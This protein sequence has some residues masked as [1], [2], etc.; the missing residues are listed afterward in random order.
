MRL[1]RLALVV[2]VGCASVQAQEP[3]PAGVSEAERAKEAAQLAAKAAEQYKLSREGRNSAP[4]IFQEKSLLQWSN[5]VVGSIHGSVF[6]W[7]ENGRPKVVASIYK[8]YGPKNFHLGVEFH[9]LT[10]EPVRAEYL[11]RPVWEPAK[12][13]LTFAPVPD[14]P[15]PAETPAARLRQMRMLAQQFT[16]VE[17]D[18]EGVRRELRL[19]TRPI[20]RENSTD[21][22][23]LDGALFT[24]V[25]GTDTEVFLL[26]ETRR[27]TDGT[28][29][30]DYGL[31]RMN[32]VEFHVSHGGR[33]VWT[34]A[35]MPWSVVFGHA[36]P[37]TVFMFDAGEGPNPPDTAQSR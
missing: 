19:L 33:E 13:G 28:L 26:I 21:P 29:G 5:P 11:G 36:E 6:V 32:S 31:A 7:T 15:A 22:S 3:R 35:E 8:W 17:K 9:S 18:R 14:A 24:F 23:V 37:Y 1:V 4:L 20:Y 2:V 30:W 27:R 12:P 25:E 10:A 34:Q 16:S